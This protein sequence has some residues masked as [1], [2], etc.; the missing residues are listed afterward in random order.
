MLVVTA[1][2]S[3]SVKQ[4]SLIESVLI[5]GKSA[6]QNHSDKKLVDKE[7]ASSRLGHP[8]RLT[9][10]LEVAARR[11][12]P[13]LTLDDIQLHQRLHV[14]SNDIEMMDLNQSYHHSIGGIDPGS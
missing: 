9:R 11:N 1:L 6:S 2:M 8:T 4:S 7:I 3:L 13:K 5:D 10:L 14:K 12:K